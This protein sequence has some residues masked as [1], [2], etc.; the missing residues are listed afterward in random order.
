MKPFKAPGLDGLH[1]GFFQRYWSI[2]G[3]TVFREVKEI[4]ANC[5]MPPHLNETLITLIPK[6]SGANSV[7]LFRPISLCNTIYKVVTK[8]I[9]KRL[10]PLLPSLISPLQTAFVP[11]RL[12]VDNM[13]IAQEIICTMSLKRGKEGYM[14]IKIDLE[15]AYDRFEWHFIQDILLLYKFPR[16][17]VKLIMSC[18]SSSSISVLFNGGKLD[19]FLPSRG[20]RQGDPM[21]PYLFI[22]CM[23]MLGYLITEKCEAK[24][25]DPVKASR[26]GPAFSHLFFADD[27][28]LFAKA[29]LKNCCHVREA[30]DTFCDLSG[31]KV[32]HHKSK[33]YFSPNVSQSTRAE[34]S[35]VLGF[36]STPNLGKYLGFPLKHPG[37]TSR[38]FN[39]IIER[40]QAK[41]QGWKANMLS[42]A[43]RV[44]LSQS[45]ISAI[46]SY[47]MQGCVLPA[48][49]LNHLDRTN[50]DFLWG[51]SESGKKMHMVS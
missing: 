25:W 35:D 17:L 39:F 4:F 8:M 10:R 33:V 18:V 47:V 42:M 40:V 31:Q 22:L 34:L 50:R 49:V 2:V 46:P 23:E 16:Q 36:S 41:L 32:S 51:A 26:N 9:V 29:D 21:S 7:G 19:P 1:V 6:C 45:V 38:D 13:I 5:A 44:I 27:L 20:I 3:E 43:G 24:L 37:S 30:L 15:K 48:R 28:V 14:A 11:G 12:G